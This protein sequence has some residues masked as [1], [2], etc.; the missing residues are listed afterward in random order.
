M[1]SVPGA[2]RRMRTVSWCHVRERQ[3]HVREENAFLNPIA[4]AS[5]GA[6]AFLQKRPVNAVTA[7]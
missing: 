5:R 3:Q 2:R 1:K 4:I 6:D 7:M